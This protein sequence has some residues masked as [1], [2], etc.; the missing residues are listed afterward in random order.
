MRHCIKWC[1]WPQDQGLLSEEGR[2]TAAPPPSL[3]DPVSQVFICRF[4]GLLSLLW[5][6]KKK[7]ELEKFMRSVAATSHIF[8]HSRGHL[9]YNRQLQFG[10]QQITTLLLKFITTAVFCGIGYHSYFICTEAVNWGK[11]RVQPNWISTLSNQYHHEGL[12]IAPCREHE[13][14]PHSTAPTEWVG[15][16]TKCHHPY[17]HWGGPNERR[18]QTVRLCS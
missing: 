17:R 15:S 11:Q 4:S 2:A 13:Y 3:L 18:A 10:I 7:E 6:S 9:I 12:G 8:W 16:W 1:C 5:A 14:Y